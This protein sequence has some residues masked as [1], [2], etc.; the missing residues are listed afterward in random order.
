MH[1][2]EY[3]FGC[4]MM[5]HDLLDEGVRVFKAVRDRYDGTERNPWNEIECGSNYARSMASWAAVL[6]LAGFSFD[7]HEARI[8][9]DPKL[10]DGLA[11]RQFWSNG[12]A[13]GT[14]EFTA[15]HFALAV[16]HGATTLAVL[17]LPVG[18]AA[19]DVTLN[20]RRLA[21]HARAGRIS[22]DRTELAAGDVLRVSCAALSVAGLRDISSF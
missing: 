6:T 21:A 22:F 9:F 12:T 13:W 14:A 3:A 18:D 11:S 16:L 15:R 5:Q 1:G 19:V 4:A 8:G 2:F 20:E 7:A 10:R 17:T